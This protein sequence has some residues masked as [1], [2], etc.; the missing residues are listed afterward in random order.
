MNEWTNTKFCS[1]LWKKY[2]LNS[3]LEL[4]LCCSCSMSNRRL[5]CLEDGE[6]GRED[7]SCVWVCV[8]GEKGSRI[9]YMLV[10]AELETQKDAAPNSNL[11][12]QEREW[13]WREKEKDGSFMY[14]FLFC[15]NEY[16][17]NW[18]IQQAYKFICMTPMLKKN[19]WV[20]NRPKKSLTDR[21]K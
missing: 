11:L 19:M 15:F 2:L 18:W 7:G 9:L 14:L 6:P 17:C 16:S 1:A 8:G 12:E 13:D 3:W 4:A 20:E 21:Y 5:N 10:W